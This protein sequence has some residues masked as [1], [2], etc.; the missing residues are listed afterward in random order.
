MSNMF[1]FAAAF[2]QPIGSWNTTNVTNMASMFVNATTFNQ[3]IGRWDTTNVT[4]MSY[5]FYNASNFNQY[6]R[7][8]N[9]K[10]LLSAP[11]NFSINS[12]LSVLNTPN[13]GGDP[14]HKIILDSISGI[15]IKW[16]GLNVPSP[17][18]V[19]ANPRGT[20]QPE[21]FAIVDDT[22]KSEIT[23]YATTGTSSYFT[24]SAHGQTAPVP[25]N[26]IVT[27]LMTDMSG[28]FSGAAL[29][30]Q[31]I[32]SLDTSNVTD[33]SAMFEGAQAFDQPIGNWN[34]RSVTDM[35][36]MFE[37]AQAFDKPIGTWNTRSVTDMSA[38]FYGAEAFDKPIGTWNTRSVTDM[39][40]MFEGAQAFDKPIGTWNTSSVTN[41]SRMFYGAEAFD[42]PIGVLS[43]IWNTTNVT[44]M[45][46][47]FYGASIFNQFI[48]SWNVAHLSEPDEFSTGSSLSALNTPNWGG[49]PTNTVIFDTN[50]VTLKWTGPNV[51]SPYFVQANPRGTPQPE[52]FAIVDDTTKS[53]ITSYAT[54]GTSSYFTPSANGQTNPV[55]FN[56]IVTTLMTDMSGMF[57]GASTFNQNIGSWDRTNVTDMSYMFEGASAFNQDLSNDWRNISSVTKNMRGMFYGASMFNQDIGLWDMLN[58]TDT[59]N[60]FYGAT[61]F[62]Q[63][64]SSWNR[65]NMINSYN[66]MFENYMY[67]AYIKDTS[68]Y[69]DGDD[70]YDT[71]QEVDEDQFEINLTNPF[72]IDSLNFNTIY[73][74]SNGTIH[75]KQ[76]DTSFTF[77]T[78]WNNFALFCFGADLY[79]TEDDFIR[80]KETDDQF[81]IIYNCRYYIDGEV[82]FDDTYASVRFQV[83]ITLHLESS[84][85]SG[86][87]TMDFGTITSIPVPTIFGISF[88]SEIE[89]NLNTNI[90]FLDHPESNPYIFNSTNTPL[91]E[92]Q[93]MQLG[94]SNK[95]LVIRPTQ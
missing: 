91:Q 79:V 19:Q 12:S 88:G 41:M 23:S 24:P 20:P 18:F 46:Y 87:I 37:G 17:Y 30:D 9:V 36:A 67:E 39:S 69:N 6:I 27:T 50:G 49:E 48:R 82:F 86:M 73:I 25:F 89:S 53:E 10:H 35:S 34:T 47:M 3:P 92:I 43:N 77:P 95:Q 8:W 13:W 11:L 52:W 28:M 70:S 90:N 85:N 26:N 58:V 51:P 40:A 42:Q 2:N 16:T 56:N 68:D 80:Y 94:Y 83:K 22:T 84:S 1:S 44:N 7:S 32:S 63:D 66:S 4:Y 5:M 45:D 72:I 60:M 71:I 31:P 62:N 61:A 29:F 54:T 81:I 93:D 76:A 21:W 14:I 57:E 15:T 74:H 75:F 59:R 78:P 55:P 65:T 38:M 64:I 33:M